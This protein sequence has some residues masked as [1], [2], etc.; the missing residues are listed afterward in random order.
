MKQDGTIFTVCGN[1]NNRYNGD[2]ILAKEANVSS[3]TGVFVT[4]NNEMYL[5][6]YNGYRIRKVDGKGIISTIAGNGFKGYSGD[7][8]F[9]FLKYPHI[10]QRKNT[11]IKP[12]PKAFFDISIGLEW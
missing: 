11:L 7:V 6:E 12:F 9:D 5:S 3:V 1:G 10:G 2:G 4:T 8:P